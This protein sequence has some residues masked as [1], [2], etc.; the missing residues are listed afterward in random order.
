MWCPVIAKKNGKR[1]PKEVYALPILDEWWSDGLVLS[2]SGDAFTWRGSFDR[3]QITSS[4][5]YGS[6][7]D[8]QGSRAC[9]LMRSLCFAPSRVVVTKHGLL[10][11]PSDG[12]VWFRITQN[13]RSQKLEAKT[14]TSDMAVVV[15]MPVASVVAT[16]LGNAAGVVREYEMGVGVT[17]AKGD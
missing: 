10:K 4:S 11:E 13:A 9:R 16:R 8:K 7:G 3:S 14:E 6:R 5:S 12:R 1:S 2:R 15:A 17:H